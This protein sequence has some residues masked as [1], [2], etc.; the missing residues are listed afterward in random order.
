MPDLPQE[1]IDAIVDVVPESSLGACSLTATAFVVSSQRRLFR[2]MS[3]DDI[4]SYER[5]AHL[6]VSSPHLGPYFRYLALVIKDIPKDYAPL[7]SILAPLTEIEYLTISGDSASAATPNQIAQNPCLIDLLSIPTLRCF[8]LQ[9]LVDVP[10]SIISRALSSF[11]EVELFRVSIANEEDQE[12]EVL[13]S[14]GGLW[15]L[16]ILFD[17]YESLLPF[18]LHPKRIESLHQLG[19]L[20]V[21]IPPIPELL[22]PRFRELLVACSSTLEHLEIELGMC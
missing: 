20:S 10:S 11:E 22:Q 13:S 5:T 17:G 3:L 12:E 15:H 2:W 7:E 21:V 18:V 9:D 8:A 19:R 4:P 16:N 14:P 6:L 1:L